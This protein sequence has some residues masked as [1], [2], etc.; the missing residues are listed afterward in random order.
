MKIV[1]SKSNPS[2]LLVTLT[3]TDNLGKERWIED[4]TQK[5]EG[6]LLD[7]ELLPPPDAYLYKIKF[8]SADFAYEARHRLHELDGH[9]E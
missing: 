3:G 4:I 5:Y 8:P 1:N 7:S 2:I 6:T 9:W